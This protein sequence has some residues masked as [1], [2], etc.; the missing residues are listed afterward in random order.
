M[1]VRVEEGVI[2][3]A[4]RC[5]AED[6]ESL[7]V[8][9]QEDPSRTVD[10]EAVQRLHLAVAQVLFAA[11]PTVRGTPDSDFLARHLVNVLQ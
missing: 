1:S 5:L 3:L 2:H 11:R 4:G 10:L 6:A 8:A 7:L 9:L